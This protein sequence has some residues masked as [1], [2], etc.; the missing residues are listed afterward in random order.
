MNLSP[1]RRELMLPVFNESH[2]APHVVA[3]HAV[4]PDQFRLAAW[5][6]KIDLGLTVAKDVDVRRLMII[7]KDHEPE[8]RSTEDRDHK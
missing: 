7:G 6:D 5:A 1:S 8:A 4:S 2:G 3:F